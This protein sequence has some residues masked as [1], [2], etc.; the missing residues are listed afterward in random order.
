[1]TPRLSS[2]LPGLDPAPSRGTGRGRGTDCTPSA[3]AAGT[4]EAG[5]LGGSEARFV[6]GVGLGPEK[7]KI[8]IE[9]QCLVEWVY[10]P[11][12]SDK[13]ASAS[14]DVLSRSSDP[15]L[16]SSAAIL[17]EVLCGLFCVLSNER[18]VCFGGAV[19]RL[20]IK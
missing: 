17:A 10:V 12:T 3:F 9:K 13:S 5:G 14:F 7:S 6:D 4:I 2:G 19:C 8:G 1:M 16:A 18:V 20:E 11:R 15:N